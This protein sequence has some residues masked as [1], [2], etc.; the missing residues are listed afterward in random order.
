MEIN[1]SNKV[2]G[3]WRLGRFGLIIG[4]I[5]AL[6]DIFY[7][8]VLYEKV[9]TLYICVFAIYAFSSII[10]PQKKEVQL[11][12]HFGALILRFFL[13]FG[14]AAVFIFV[15]N[16]GGLDFGLNYILIYLS[17]LGFE[18]YSLIN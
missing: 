9:W 11:M 7:P 17:F 14:C 3:L 6:L 16:A 4:C 1:V 10:I 15:A 12:F 2:Y 5:I 8:A 18:I 13:A